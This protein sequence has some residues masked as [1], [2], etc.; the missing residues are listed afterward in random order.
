MGEL[1]TGLISL[2]GN[3]CGLGGGFRGGELGILTGV[4]GTE[5]LFKDREWIAVLR[6]ACTK[7]RG[8]GLDYGA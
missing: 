5:L 4:V 8:E 1:D 6:V 3:I 7:S 2:G